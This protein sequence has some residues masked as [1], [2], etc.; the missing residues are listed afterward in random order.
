MSYAIDVNILVYASDTASPYH[1]RAFRFLEGCVAGPELVCLPWPTLIGY[2]RVST[3]PAVSS[4]PLTS[5]H[6]MEN[7]DRLLRCPNVR[8]L[9]EEE[10]FWDAFRHAAHGLSVRGNLVSDC[11]IAAL[12]VEHGVKVIYTNDADFRRFGFLE[13]RNPLE[14]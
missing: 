13:V 14:K 6:A 8:V 10:G 12:L 9:P 5:E 11:H 3:H 7:V 4:A 1:E 2:L